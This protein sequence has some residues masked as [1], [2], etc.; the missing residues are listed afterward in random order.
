M[1][2]GSKTKNKNNRRTSNDFQRSI[3]SHENKTASSPF[4]YKKFLIENEYKTSI[5]NSD[6]SFF[7]FSFVEAMA[8]PHNS[9]SAKCFMSWQL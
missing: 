8:S 4:Y 2:N 5:G 7:V 6:L 3:S 9:L 1:P